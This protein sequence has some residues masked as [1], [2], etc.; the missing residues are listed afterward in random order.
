MST[1]STIVPHCERW[2]VHPQ[3][4]RRVMQDIYADVMAGNDIEIQPFGVFKKSQAKAGT[5]IYQNIVS[6]HEDKEFVSLRRPRRVPGETHTFDSWM[7]LAYQSSSAPFSPQ[8][9]VLISGHELPAF[10]VYLPDFIDL[11]GAEMITGF[12]TGGTTLGWRLFIR[13]LLPAEGTNARLDIDWTI[14]KTG[15]PATQQGRARFRNFNLVAGQQDNDLKMIRAYNV[16]RRSDGELIDVT[17]SVEGA[18]FDPPEVFSR[19]M[20]SIVR[21]RLKPPQPFTDIRSRA[22]FH[23]LPVPF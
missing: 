10:Q 8:V 12:I 3:T 19:E 17:S 21:S 16:Q 6:Q 13:I 4:F 5:K 22:S 1:R 14:S 18:F 11:A 15:Y 9:A 20:L 7:A 23:A 2:G